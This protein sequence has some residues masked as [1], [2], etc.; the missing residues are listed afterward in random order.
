M[1]EG[2][3]KDPVILFLMHYTGRG[4]IQLIEEL[5]SPESCDGGEYGNNH[6]YQGNHRQ[7]RLSVENFKD[8]LAGQFTGW[9][10]VTFVAFGS[11]IIDAQE[12][13]DLHQ[14]AS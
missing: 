2:V 9:G 10:G 7:G 5:P 11:H 14:L 13:D 1:E 12:G 4:K 8:Q 6:D 3:G